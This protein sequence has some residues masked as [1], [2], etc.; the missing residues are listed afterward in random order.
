M[1]ASKSGGDVAGDPNPDATATRDRCG[2]PPPPTCSRSL[3]RL[4]E[5]FRQ[6]TGHDI[7]LTLDASGRLAEQIKAGAPFDVFLA[8]NRS[9]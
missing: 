7:L 5:R 1:T 9:S 2:S 3:P 4:A 6:R 8:A